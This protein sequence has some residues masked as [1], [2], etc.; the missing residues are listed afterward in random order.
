MSATI[1]DKVPSEISQLLQQIFETSEREVFDT[2]GV[3]D[4]FYGID[5]DEAFEEF[6]KVIRTYN[7]KAKA[8]S[9]EAKYLKEREKAHKTYAE[10]LTKFVMAKMIQEN[11]FE[12]NGLHGFRLSIPTNNTVVSIDEDAVVPEKFMVQPEKVVDKK[13]LKTALE[14]GEEIEGIRLVP[15]KPSL[16][17]I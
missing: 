10:M 15:Q 14:D 1:Y 2:Y 4:V 17:V 13:A 6:A 5:R 9:E 12:T 8:F 11:I 3:S 16:K 7:A